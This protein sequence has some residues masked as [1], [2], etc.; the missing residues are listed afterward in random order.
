MSKLRSKELTY[1]S[2]YYESKKHQFVYA[3]TRLLSNLEVR[4][5]QRTKSIH[6]VV[7]DITHRHTLIHDAVRKIIEK[8]KTMFIDRETYLN[9]QRHKLLRLMNRKIFA[10]VERLITHEAIEMIIRE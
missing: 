10:K 9:S 5:S 1:L 3:Y 2:E 4:S 6:S 8:M 7:K